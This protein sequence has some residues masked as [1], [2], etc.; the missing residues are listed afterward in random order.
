MMRF[1]DLLVFVIVGCILSAGLIYLI[2]KAEPEYT[3]ISG[4][5][6]VKKPTY[7]MS[8]DNLCVVIDKE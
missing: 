5:L 3:C 2:E 1:Q 8:T 4:K 7:Y 6:Y